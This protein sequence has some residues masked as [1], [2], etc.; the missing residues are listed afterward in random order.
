[1]AGMKIERT[2]RVMKIGGSYVVA[3]PKEM[4]K[5]L[6]IRVGDKIRMIADQEAI[7]MV[8]VK[9]RKEG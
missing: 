5:L 6:G 8:K 4:R 1:M 3:L 7:L 2:R 9:W